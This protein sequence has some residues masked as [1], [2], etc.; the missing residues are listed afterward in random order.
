MKCKRPTHAQ[1]SA[2]LK[3]DPET[4][5]VRWRVTLNGGA[6]AGGIAGCVEKRGHGAYRAIRLFGHKQYAHRIAWLLKTGEWPEDYV[7]HKDGD[8][9][10]NKWGNLRKATPSQ[11]RCNSRRSS[12]NRSGYK[13]VGEKRN[14]KHT[15]TIGKGKCKQ[16]VGRYAC[17]KEGHEA[18]KEAARETFGEF[19]RFD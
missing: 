10:N 7:D 19:A 16:V 9:L 4:G 3:Y 14:G 6:K 11:N 15:V 5:D 17:P 13:G 12:R 1:V 18:Y 2:V 8:G